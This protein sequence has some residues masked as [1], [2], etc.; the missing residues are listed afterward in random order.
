MAN[1]QKVFSRENLYQSVWNSDFYG[2]DNARQC[3][4]QQYPQ[5]AGGPYD[6]E[7]IQ[8]VWGIGYKF[9]VKS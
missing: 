6:E 1:P 8:T 3:P 5:K 7:Y 4:H 9:E 2:E